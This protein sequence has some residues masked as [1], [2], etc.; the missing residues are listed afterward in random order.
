M[1][2]VATPA[3]AEP[4]VLPEPG[5]PE[6]KDPF[7]VPALAATKVRFPGADLVRPQAQP[8]PAPETPPAKLGETVREVPSKSTPVP[9]VIDNREQKAV[10][11]AST[12]QATPQPATLP[13]GFGD[14]VRAMVAKSAPTV[15]RMPELANS[16]KAAA[17]A[18]APAPK[19][20]QE[21]SFSPTI[22]IDVQGDVK[23]PSQVVREIESPL[24]QLFEA[25]QREASARMSSAQLYDQPHV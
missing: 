8:Q 21:F 6:V 20:D 16:A 17:P 25:W 10:A 12:P 14:V 3:P 4:A 1:R 23:D 9:V 7:L 19:V 2:A 24:R 18:P 22:K 15:P 5:A 11:E 13:A